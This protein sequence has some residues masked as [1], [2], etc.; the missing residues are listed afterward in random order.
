MK[1]LEFRPALP[2]LKIDRD[3]INTYSQPQAFV[4]LVAKTETSSDPSAKTEGFLVLY[5]APPVFPSG[6]HTAAGLDNKKM[7][8]TC[9]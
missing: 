5:T 6:L 3:G 8:N 7:T 2:S 9:I 4:K 1:T